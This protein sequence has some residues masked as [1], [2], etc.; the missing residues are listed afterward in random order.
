MVKKKMLI[1]PVLAIALAL[2][3]TAAVSYL[4]LS[5]Q[6]TTQNHFLAVSTPAPTSQP[7]AMY[8]M[9]ATVASPTQAPVPAPAATAP[10]APAS[11]TQTVYFLPVLFVAVAV[12]L[13]VVAVQ[14]L[15]REKDLRKELNS[16]GE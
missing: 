3:L 11:A 15:F 8:S 10:P 14:V 4:P 2:S 13:G 7:G 9:N 16:E 6:A 5:P 1:A 12:V